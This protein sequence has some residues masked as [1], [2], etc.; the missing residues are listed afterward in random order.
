LAALS[1]RA[2]MTFPREIRGFDAGSDAV[3]SGRCRMH[4]RAGQPPWV[5]VV[6]RLDRTNIRLL[7]LLQDDARRTV[8]DLA[9]D[10]GRAESTVRERLAA[11]ERDGVLRGYRAHVDAEK[12]GL[13]ARA[14]LRANMD[15]RRVPDVIRDLAAVPEVTGAYLTTGPKPVVL[16]V[17][18]MDLARLERVIERRI[19][20]IELEDL[21]MNAVVRTLV[22]E[23]PLP[24]RALFARPPAVAMVPDMRP[25]V[26]PEG[27]LDP[28]A[29]VRP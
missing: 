24:L 28:S 22:E 16:E 12:L 5:S 17:T 6:V 29:Y 18:A 8:A 13:H 7:E 21:E 26:L 23:R 9:R 1:L 20:P 19:A 10:V 27:D 14:F 25:V 11:L 15:P 3:L 4:G 2:R